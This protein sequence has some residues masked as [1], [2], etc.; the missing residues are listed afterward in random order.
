MAAC[1]EA[2]DLPVSALEDSYVSYLAPMQWRDSP[3]HVAE[4]LWQ[5]AQRALTCLSAR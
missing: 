1:P 4:E 5:P 3:G 2:P